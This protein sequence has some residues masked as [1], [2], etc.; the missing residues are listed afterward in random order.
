M[1]LTAHFILLQADAAVLVVD[2][3]PGEFEVAISGGGQV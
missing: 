2:A 3:T 1:A